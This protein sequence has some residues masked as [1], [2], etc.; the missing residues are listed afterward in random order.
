MITVSYY[1]AAG[2]VT[3]S[4]YL[5]SSGRARVLVDFGMHQGGHEDDERNARLPPL[6]PSELD[7]VV[8]THAHL[9]HC[10]RLPL[11]VR[12]G[13]E[14]PVYCTPATRTLTGIILRDSAALQEADA[15]DEL[16][17]AAAQGRKP[18]E[19]L[20]TVEQA[21]LCLDRLAPVCYQRPVQVAPG[22][23]VRFLDSGH[24]IGAASVL[25][26]VDGGNPGAARRTIL[27]SG[28]VGVAG[29]PILRDPTLPTP[30]LV[31]IPD[32]VILEST[33]GDR[34]HRPLSATIDEFVGILDAA[35]RDDGKILIPAFAVGR[36]QDL[37]Y[38]L[39]CLRR[40]SRIPFTHVYIDS[41]MATATSSLYADHPELYDS[42]AMALKLGGTDPLRF[43]GLRHTST[44]EESKSLN[45]LRGGGVI[46]A[47]SGMCTGGRIVHHLRNSL[48]SPSTHVV[49]V[50]YQ[51]RGTL[52]RKLV[53]GATS[54]RIFNHQIDV[55]AKVHTLGGFSAHAG[56]TALV[57]WGC[58]A[59]GHGDSTRTRLALTHGEEHPRH[60]LAEK[61]RHHTGV[62]AILPVWGDA[63]EL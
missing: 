32:L 42:E 29:A 26:T 33:Y 12:H 47:G 7:A 2:E 15:E 62:Q 5:V 38:H 21:E 22:I 13:F 19:P 40:E 58:R 43:P 30:D 6:R 61:I 59:I 28:D 48:A 45:S 1:G 14:G 44:R 63:T 56:Q 49:I 9:D 55:R 20:Y 17:R 11:L 10:G 36:T 3:G 23:T 60:A 18:A 57:E 52:G 25:M 39:G 50:G 8:L 4:C 51:G 24:I 37:I 54:V 53:E 27:F 35:R 41:P 16:R 46:I 34:D 31:G